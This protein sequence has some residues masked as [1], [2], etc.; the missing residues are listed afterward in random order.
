MHKKHEL[1]SFPVSRYR[2]CAFSLTTMTYMNGRCNADATLNR[3][4][5]GDNSFVFWT[6]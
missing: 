3:R 5:S 6:S 1:K 4:L 2:W